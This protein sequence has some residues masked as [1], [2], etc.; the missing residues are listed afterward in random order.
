VNDEVHIDDTVLDDWEV[1]E[2]EAILQE[3]RPAKAS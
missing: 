3:G 2:K 1:E